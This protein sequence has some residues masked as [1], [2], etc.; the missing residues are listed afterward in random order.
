MSRSATAINSG[1]T[2]KRFMILA[3]VLG[4]IGAVLVYVTVSGGGG[5]SS[6]ATGDQMPV[7]VAK[8]DIAAR[9]KITASM[10]DVK[11]V[12]ESDRALLAYGETENV[13][14]QI[15]RF[16]IVAGEQVLSNKIVPLAGSTSLASQSLSFVVPEGKRAI[17]IEV[18][19]VVAA[20]GLVLPGDYVDILVVYDVEVGSGETRETLEAFLVDTIMQNVEVLAVSQ[21]IVDTVSKPNSSTNADGSTT[22][23]STSG[24]RERNS[25]ADADPAAV[26][27]TLALTPQDA[28]KLFL[29]ELNGTLRLSV[30]RFGEDGDQ[31]LEPII[32]D[33]LLPR[34]LPNS[35]TR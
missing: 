3:V 4:L 16:P 17:A 20:G 6:K 10:V 30:R 9:T 22:T 27:V 12:P 18:S 14:G 19:Q 33:D 34:N 11:L 21:T 23:I 32:E 28:Q 15:T 5:S 25:E 2:N 31:P 35:F 26:T 29:A 24:H 8:V 1:Q 13:V 7:V